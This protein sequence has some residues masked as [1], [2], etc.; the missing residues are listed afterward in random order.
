MPFVAIDEHGQRI[1]ISQVENPKELRT[2]KHYCQLCGSLVLVKAGFLRVA[3]FAHQKNCESDINHHPES[4]HHRQGKLFLMQNLPVLFFDLFGT[5]PK[6]EVIMKEIKRVADVVF[7]FPNGWR[8][9][10]EVQL[11]SVT[12]EQLEERTRDY[13]SIGCDVIWWLG[14]SAATKANREWA[15][16]RQGVI[17]EIDFEENTN[18]RIVDNQNPT[19]VTD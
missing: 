12:T 16:D 4:F 19:P 15:R 3:H 8:M 14:K 6:Q 9:V 18:I 1:D 11:A 13:E 2:K 17:F 10:H 5:L 7:E